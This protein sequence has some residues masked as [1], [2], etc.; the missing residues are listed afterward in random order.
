M[1]LKVKRRH[2][3]RMDT[4]HD[5]KNPLSTKESAGSKLQGGLVSMKQRKRPSLRTARLNAGMVSAAAL[6]RNASVPA[7]IEA[8]ETASVVPPEESLGDIKASQIKLAV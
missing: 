8:E 3:A 6:I 7:L 4:L 1:A 5:S 2:K